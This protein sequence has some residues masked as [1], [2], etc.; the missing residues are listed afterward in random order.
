MTTHK[1]SKYFSKGAKRTALSVALGMCVAGGVQAQSNTTGSVFGQAS[2]GETVVVENPATGFRRE[3]VVGADGAY[4]ISALQPGRYNVTLRRADGSTVVREAVGVSVGTGTPVSFAAAAGGDAKTLDSVVVTASQLVNPIDVSSVESTTVLTSEQIARIP[5]PRDTTSVALLAPGTVRGDAAFGNLAS[6]GG[7]SVAENQYYI[8]GFNVT[9]SFRSLNFSKVPFEA[10]AEQQVKTG[11]Y[12]AEFGRSLGGVVNQI[13]KRGTNE[14]KAGANVFWAPDSLREK[15]KNV[16]YSNPL[17]PSDFGKIEEDNSKDAEDQLITSVW[18]SGAL[19]KD[20]LFAYAL[21]SYGNTEQDTWGNKDALQNINNK[22]KNPTWL[23][24]FDWNINDNNK[25]ELTA[26]SDEQK[27]D[28]KV[29]ANTPGQLDRKAYAG[30]LFDTQGGQ[31]FVL[32]YTGYLT[33]NFTLTA[34]AGHGEFKRQQHLRNPDGSEVRYNGDINTAYTR[35][36]TGTTSLGGCPVIIDVRPGY[37]KAMTGPYGSFCNLTNGA[38]L[39]ADNN[40][41]TRD[42]YRIDA[43]WILGSHQLRFGVDIDNY[44]S[45]AGE[46]NAGGWLWRYSTNNGPDGKANTG[47]EFDVVRRQTTARGTTIEVKQRAFYIEDS[48]KVTDN[49]LAYLGL[50][51]D[52]FENLGADGRAFVKIDNQFGPRLGFSWDVNGD[53]TFKVYGNAG[54]YALP[55]TPSVAVR[56]SSASIFQRSN[57]NRFSGVDPVTGAPILTGPLNPLNLINGEDGKAHDPLTIASKNLEPMYQ[58]EYILGFQSAITDHVN[59]GARAIYRKLK[60]AIDDNCDYTAITELADADGLSYTVPNPGFPYCRLFNPGKDAV[61]VTDL[62]GDGHY[63]TYTVK[64]DRLSPDAKRSY[65][66]LELFLDGNWDKFFFQA[67]YTWSANKGNTE[68]GVK[69]DIGQS[70]TNTTQDFDYKELTVDTFGYL[71]NDRRHALKV[72]GSYQFND[73]WSLGANLLVQSGRPYNCLGVLDLDPALPDPVTG[74]N[75]Y[76]PHPYGSGFMR[77]SNSPDGASNDA[78]VHAVPRGTAGR[79]PWTTTVDLNAAYRP[80]FAPGLQFKVDVF[81]V[82]N[83]QKVIAV[84]DVAED[85]ATGNPLSTYLLPRAYQAPRSVRF[86]VQYDF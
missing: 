3:V 35:S 39:Q 34:L 4:R 24:K 14:F 17:S 22:V 62:N 26:F 21:L 27:T 74:N 5:V 25:L 12:G 2:S 43:E 85:S 68:G 50:R 69:S 63:T 49:F 48:W 8:N 16:K 86:M 72:F 6:F 78:T 53:S 31:N 58:D 42:Q 36:I 18:A 83:S 44:E 57:N 60:A 82:F 33:D 29:Y 65:K 59:L 54:R 73:Q 66:A 38:L 81:N 84:S 7:S 20:R 80:S 67:S 9:N 64:G 56:G 75:H 30:T 28:T 77:C 46:A 47:D 15:V 51:W 13:T 11:G 1:G 19:I 40:K 52:T 32:K 71:P 70:D 61:L 41:D 76:S 23:A 10:I 55:L 45:V 37:R 79:L